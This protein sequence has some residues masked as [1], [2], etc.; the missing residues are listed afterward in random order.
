MVFAFL[1]L[2]EFKVYIHLND[3]GHHGMILHIF[4]AP[5]SGCYSRGEE[6]TSTDLFEDYRATPETNSS[7][8]K[9]DGE[10]MKSPSGMAHFQVRTVCSEL[11]VFGRFC[12][13]IFCT[14]K[15]ETSG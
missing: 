4:L 12:C 15:K 7:H 11:G 8:L 14:N 5:K 13:R 9:M 6:D 10:K 1:L 3:F 2:L